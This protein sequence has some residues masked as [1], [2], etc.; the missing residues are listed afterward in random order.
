[1]KRNASTVNDYQQWLPTVASTV[2]LE[3]L[4]MP[5]RCQQQLTHNFRRPMGEDSGA[6]TDKRMAK[7][8]D[9]RTEKNVWWASE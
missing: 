6:V 4:P 5:C 9:G 8:S 1:M 3:V 2:Y 7:L